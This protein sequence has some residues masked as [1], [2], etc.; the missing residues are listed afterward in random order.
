MSLELGKRSQLR[1]LKSPR[2]EG[3]DSLSG[4]GTRQPRETCTRVSYAGHPFPH[5]LV[6][7]YSLLEIFSLRL[8]TE[9]AQMDYLFSNALLPALHITV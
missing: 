5:G 9:L 6:T 1:L 7:R 8:F 2:R 4:R 3:M